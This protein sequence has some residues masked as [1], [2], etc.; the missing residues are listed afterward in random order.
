MFN[1]IFDGKASLDE[2]DRGCESIQRLRRA[3]LQSV[4]G[5][6]AQ[7]DNGTQVNVNVAQFQAV[8]DL[9]DVHDD[10]KL[11]KKDDADVAFLAQ[12][13]A[14]GRSQIGGDMNIFI[15]NVATTILIFAKKLA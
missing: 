11:V 7:F 2:L 1:R 9:N 13:A 10:L 3:N 15:S 8:A 5:R 4:E 14:E 12:M 6:N